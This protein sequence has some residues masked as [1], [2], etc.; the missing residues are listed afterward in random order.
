MR[1][2]IHEEEGRM[3]LARAVQ[4]NRCGICALPLPCGV[5]EH[6]R[7]QKRLTVAGE[8]PKG[9]TTN[10]AADEYP[11]AVLP[12]LQPLRKGYHRQIAVAV[13]DLLDDRRQQ[14]RQFKLHG[15]FERRKKKGAVKRQVYNKKT[16]FEAL[17]RLWKT[18]RDAGKWEGLPPWRVD[19]HL[20]GP[21]MQRYKRLQ[22]KIRV[23]EYRMHQLAEAIAAAQATL[24]GRGLPRVP[25]PKA[26]GESGRPGTGRSASSARQH[27]GF[28]SQ[29]PP[30]S[31]R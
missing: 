2:D 17:M 24:A 10:T 15:G 26:F 27:G 14:R 8:Q 4:F 1:S 20:V 31:A 9:P 23:N 18:D 5:T 16:A 29:L 7:R 13:R 21:C 6:I 30:L 28:A 25:V 3:I 22:Q 12:D 19:S 11:K